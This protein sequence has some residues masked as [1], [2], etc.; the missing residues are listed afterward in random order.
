MV[1]ESPASGGPTTTGEVLLAEIRDTPLSVDECLSAV[2][3]AEVGGVALFV[4]M[5]RDHDHDRPVIELDYSAHPSGQAELARVAGEIAAL[6]GIRT[7]AVVHRT[8]SLRVGDLAVVTAVGAAH[9]AEA[10]TACRRLID[11]V[12]ARVPIW[13]HQLFADGSAEW[14][15]SC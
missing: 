11:D 15:G 5:V 3:T 10:F 7:V 1:S 14:V 8:G 12:K 9:R 4:G 6:D 13:K 2:R